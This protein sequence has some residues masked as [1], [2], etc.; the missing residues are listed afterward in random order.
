MKII[1]SLLLFCALI[2]PAF[3]DGGL[4]TNILRSVTGAV[5][6]KEAPAPADKTA[7]LG[8][9]GMD[10]D[11]TKAPAPASQGIKSLESWAVGRVEAET[12]AGQRGLASRSVQYEPASPST[13]T[14]G[15]NIDIQGPK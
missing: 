12:A 7:V 2:P 1:L 6:G 15:N 10:E 3:A 14:T 8:I 9:R 5:G 13:G 11:E 4:F